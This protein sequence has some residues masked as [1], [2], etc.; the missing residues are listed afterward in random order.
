MRTRR[1]GD[2]ELFPSGLREV[3]S[4]VGEGVVVVVVVASG[5]RRLGWDGEPAIS[6]GPFGTPLRFVPGAIVVADSMVCE[7]RDG[8]EQS[9]KVGGT[10]CSATMQ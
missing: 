7:E 4:I 5:A 10:D 6:S 1:G 8:A 9:S 3:G 2:L